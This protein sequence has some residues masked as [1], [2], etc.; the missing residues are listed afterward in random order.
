MLFQGFFMAKCPVSGILLKFMHQSQSA[1]MQTC[2][3]IIVTDISQ[4]TRMRKID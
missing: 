4:G 1:F 3:L 2:I